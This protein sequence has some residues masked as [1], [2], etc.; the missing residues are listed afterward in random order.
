MQNINKNKPYSTKGTI[1]SYTFPLSKIVTPLWVTGITDAEG[2]F[3]INTA[4]KYDKTHLAYKVSQK[5]HSKSI[6]IKLQ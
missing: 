2:N 6:L 3:S 1:A 5:T 4:F